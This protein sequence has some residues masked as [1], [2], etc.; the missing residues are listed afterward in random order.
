MILSATIASKHIIMSSQAAFTTTDES[1]TTTLSIDIIE[2]GTINLDVPNDNSNDT[3]N[4][5]AKKTCFMLSM[6]SKSKFQL[7]RRSKKALT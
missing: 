7:T 6:I 4:D 3:S 5:V 1:A 2:L